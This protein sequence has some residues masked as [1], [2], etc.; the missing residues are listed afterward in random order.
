MKQ[1]IQDKRCMWHWLAGWYHKTTHYENLTDHIDAADLYS[2]IS[3]KCS[4][5]F[6]HPHPPTRLY[7]P[8]ALSVTIIVLTVNGFCL[9]CLIELLVTWKP[10][11]EVK[12][13]QQH[14]QLSNVLSQFFVYKLSRTTRSCS[15][16]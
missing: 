2:N 9:T 4:K 13:S 6:L 7:F 5:P 16:K 15:T 14:Q 11:G 3:L 1:A 10:G 12:A 8:P